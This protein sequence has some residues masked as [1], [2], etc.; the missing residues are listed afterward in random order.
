MPWRS[1]DSP[2]VD[3]STR[4]VQKET[5]AMAQTLFDD[6]SAFRGSFTGKVITPADAD[7]D[8]ARSVWNGAI[9]RRPAVIARCAT[10]EQVADAVQ[11]G[12]RQGLEIAVRG[13]GHNFA[14]F[15]VCEGGL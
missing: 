2:L 7:Y 12:R 10:A 11:F 3:P 4:S 14:G 9:D 13:G 6:L 15:G 8:R 1:P 5:P